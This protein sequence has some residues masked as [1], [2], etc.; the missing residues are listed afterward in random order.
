MSKLTPEQ[1]QKHS[2]DMLDIMNMAKSREVAVGITA[3]KATEQ[4]YESGANVL[5]V[6]TW[7]EFGRGNPKRSF[8]NNTFNVKTKDLKKKNFDTF[9]LVL[10]GGMSVDKGLGIMGAYF[11]NFVKES[12]TNNGYGSWAPLEAETIENK[13]SS[14]TLIDTGILR[15]SITWQVRTIK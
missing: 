10:N 12:F 6:G 3:D 7:H 13:G 11:T 5:E 1:M 4:A 8:L 9:Q 2:A 14:R 15:R